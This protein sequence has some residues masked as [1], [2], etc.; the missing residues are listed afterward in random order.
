MA[1]PERL[2]ELVNLLI[3]RRLTHT[4]G[5]VSTEDLL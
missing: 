3:K 4:M 1:A 5:W 2:V